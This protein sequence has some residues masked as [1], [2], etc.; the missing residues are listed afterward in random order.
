MKIIV[1]T[2]LISV[3]V[4]PVSNHRMLRY[5]HITEDAGTGPFQ[6]NPTYN[7]STGLAT[8]TQTLFN[9]SA[10][11]VWAVDHTVPLAVNG[12]FVGGSDYRFPLTK[13]TLNSRNADG[14]IGAVVATSPKTD[15]CMTGDTRVGDVPNTPSQTFIPV[16]NCDDPTKPLGWSVGWG[17]QYDQTDAGQPIDINAL[18]NGTYV[19]KA[20]VD[21]EHVL[22]EGDRTNNVTTTVLTISGTTVTVGAQ[23][24]PVTVPPTVSLTSPAPSSTVSGTAQLT[25]AAAATAP[26]TV[27]SVQYLLDGN[28]LGPVLT[29]SP[30]AYTWTIGST[31]PGSHDLSARVT[32]SAGN[33]ATAAVVGVNVAASGTPPG[34]TVD[35][36]ISATG[37]GTVSTA[38]FSPRFAGETFVAFVSADGPALAAGQSAT[39]SGGGLTWRRVSQA[40]TQFGDSEIWTS[41]A[42]GTLASA[43][44]STLS[45][46]GFDQQLAVLTFAGAGGTGASATASAASGAP[47]VNIVPSKTGSL[48]YAVGNDWD[49]AISR[50]PGTGQALVAQWADSATGDTFWVQGSTT[51]TRVSGA[52]MPV[53]DTAPTA[54]R[55]NLAAVEVVPSTSTPPDTTLPTVAITNPAPGQTVSGTTP[56]AATATDNVAIRSVQF[57]LDG[58]ALG[59]PVTTSPFALQWNTTTAS[60]GG[61]TISAVATD[62][63]G[64]QATS[65]PVAV[66]VTNPAPPMTCFVMQAQTSVHGTGA[67]TTPAFHTAMAGELLVAFVAS[68]GPAATASQTATVSGAGLTWTLARRANGQYGDSEIWTAP[69]P[70][71]LTSATVTSTPSVGGF[72]Q[73]LTVIAMEGTSGIGA[74]AAAS[75]VSGA[76]AVSLTTT[77]A[78]SLVF[79]VG[80]DWDNATARAFPTGLVLLDQ[81][82]DTR[83]G[84]TMW[85]EYTNQPTGAA[86][87]RITIGTTAPTTDRWNFVAVELKNDDS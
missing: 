73:A 4:D 31:S 28:P 24:R 12:A 64:N 84:D 69:A 25:V 80:N 34:F 16:S 78:T 51:G 3:A 70:A 68:D 55:W 8:F 83:T 65:A 10:P 58:N 76:A 5:T 20:T 11:G 45:Q 74:S 7:P 42:S 39:V 47:S 48:V 46:A 59:A 26:A 54:D 9:S 43:V 57:L 14:T 40:H 22:T 81:W 62:T 35:R 1:P 71:I 79:A 30:F 75:A 41:T 67:V 29:S 52:S 66:T 77:S 15:Y 85:S 82:T 63:S 19:L 86:A 32:D 61:H 60:A 17:D 38:S 36:S 37:H 23:A 6:I 21:P 33:V 50:V 27:S 72:D 2:N 53:G 49:A 18:P 56:V 44:T 13:F 87:S